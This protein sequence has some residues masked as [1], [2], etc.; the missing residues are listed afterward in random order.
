MAARRFGHTST[1]AFLC[2]RARSRDPRCA[3]AGALRPAVTVHAPLGGV[4]LVLAW[5]I[6]LVIGHF[7]VPRRWRRRLPERG[8]SRPRLLR[9]WSAP[10]WTRWRADVGS[11][12]AGGAPAGAEALPVQ[13]V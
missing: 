5:W 9:A 8:S 4:V 7:A 13:R 12:V 3:P 10:R 1:R 6:S 11:S 2:V